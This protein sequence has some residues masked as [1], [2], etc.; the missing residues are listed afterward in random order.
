MKRFKVCQIFCTNRQPSFIFIQTT[1]FIF[2]TNWIHGLDY[3][4]EEICLFR[5]LSNLK[6]FTS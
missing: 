4:L 5:L 2:I 6:F 3:L 1:M